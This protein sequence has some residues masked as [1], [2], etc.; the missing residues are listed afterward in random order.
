MT[1]APADVQSLK[2]EMAGMGHGSSGLADKLI[3]DI[4]LKQSRIGHKLNCIMIKP[5]SQT[6]GYK[7]PTPWPTK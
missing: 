4:L 2:V 3:D 6:K 1:D 7:K 5:R